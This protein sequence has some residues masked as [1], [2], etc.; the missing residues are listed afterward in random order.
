M[1]IKEIKITKLQNNSGQ[2]AGL[3]KNPRFIRD[4]RFEKLVQSIRDFPEMLKLRELVAV[5]HE[6]KYVVIG[7]NMRLR[8]IKQVGY[9]VATCKVL[10]EDTPVEKLREFVIKDNVAFGNDSFEELSNEWEQNE[11][12]DWGMELPV[13]EE[14]D[15][16]QETLPKEDE[17]DMIAVTLTD[18]EKAEW[19]KAKEYLKIKNDKKAIFRLVEFMWQ[20]ENE[21]KEA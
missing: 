17:T 21:N 11:L 20:V 16:E 12:T 3:P 6:G 15:E 2:I 18:S 10:P 8:A 14:E 19:L 13:F 5:E 4:E 1:E 9:T 7:G